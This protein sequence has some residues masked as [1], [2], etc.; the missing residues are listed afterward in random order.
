MVNSR[1]VMAALLCKAHNA[2]TPAK[3]DTLSNGM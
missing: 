2:I 1:R 3:R